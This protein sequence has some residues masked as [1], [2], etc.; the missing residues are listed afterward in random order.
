MLLLLLGICASIIAL[1]AHLRSRRHTT[2]EL[3]ARLPW[4]DA[5]IL[6][7]DFAALRRADVLQV[8]AAPVDI[9]E[10]EYRAFV[11]DTGFDYL[12]DLDF[13]LVSFHGDDWFFLLRGRFNWKKV[14]EYVVRQGGSCYNS[15]CQLAGSTP[16]RKISLLPLL[17]DL[18][19]LAIGKDEWLA[20]RLKV[21]QAG[22]PLS[23]L[24]ARPVWS[25]VPA[26][27]LKKTEALPPVLAAFAKTLESAESVVLALGLQ[28]DGMEA[29]LESTC[30]SPGEAASL[31]S[32]LQTATSLLRERMARENRQPDPRDLTGP[33]AA[34]VF[35]QQDSRVFGRWLIKWAFFEA[36][37]GGP[38]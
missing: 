7:I 11:M 19:G 21:R 37:A 17:P 9:Q 12:E 33:L 5:I 29:L 36:L 6:S 25:V 26:S 35:R 14:G 24:P 1:V 27:V 28:A 3:L 13:A 30:R 18:M 31:A 34:G 16:E 2:A 23:A 22:R 20:D 4:D 8:L 10:P 32:Q 15:F 38:R